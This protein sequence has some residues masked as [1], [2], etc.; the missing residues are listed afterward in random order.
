MSR[1]CAIHPAPGA[2]L[3]GFQQVGR[4]PA[5]APAGP[6]AARPR[7]FRAIHDWHLKVPR[8]LCACRSGRPYSRGLVAP[9]AVA[10]PIAGDAPWR[11]ASGLALVRPIVRNGRDRSVLW[12]EQDSRRPSGAVHSPLLISKGSKKNPD[13]T[14]S[15]KMPTG[16][17]IGFATI[18]LGFALELTKPIYLYAAL[19]EY[20][21]HAKK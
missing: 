20:N 2:Y 14:Y 10:R 21:K 18:G 19:N 6:G 3:P 5:D 11:G 9:P 7:C 8:L 15:T 12:G 1:P 13:G 17:K 16:V 4:L